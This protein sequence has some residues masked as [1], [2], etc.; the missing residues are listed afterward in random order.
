MRHFEK[1]SFCSGGNLYLTILSIYTCQAFVTYHQKDLA[2]CFMQ[3]GIKLTEFSS[4]ML[5]FNN[6]PIWYRTNKDTAHT[7]TN[8]LTHPHKYIL[9][10]TVMCSHQLSILHWM[11]KL[12][13]SKIHFT[14]FHNVFAFKKLLFCKYHVSVD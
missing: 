7:W 13:I 5:F 6:T 9:T 2:V 3:Q 14:E 11:N 10:W 12:V 1:L 4:I 8:R